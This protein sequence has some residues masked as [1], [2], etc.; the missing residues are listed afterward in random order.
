MVIGLLPCVLAVAAVRGSFPYAPSAPAPAAAQCSAVPP[1]QR[2]N[3]G[4]W[5]I[6]E[7]QCVARGCCF[8]EAGA[9]EYK[10]HQPPPTFQHACYYPNASVP[11]KKVHV[12]QSNHFDGG[13]HDIVGVELNQCASPISV[14]RFCAHLHRVLQLNLHVGSCQYY[15]SCPDLR[16]RGPCPP[17]PWDM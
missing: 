1:T 3:C 11:I 7:G 5:G 4:Y 13:Y 14:L 10:G 8:G 2:A 12:I 16:P 9:F 15:S 6:D 17:I